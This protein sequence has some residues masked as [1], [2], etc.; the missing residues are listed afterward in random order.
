MSHIVRPPSSMSLQF[1]DNMG[2]V[3]S[4]RTPSPLV[5]DS[6][7]KLHSL[8]SILAVVRMRLLVLKAISQIVYAIDHSGLLSDSFYRSIAETLLKDAHEIHAAHSTTQQAHLYLSQLAAEAQHEIMI[9]HHLFQL[10]YALDHFH[11]KS[12]STHLYSV[13]QNC[14]ALVSLHTQSIP[15]VRTSNW[16]RDLHVPSSTKWF[17]NFYDHMEAKMTLYFDQLLRRNH[18][19]ITNQ[20][21]S[22]L[23]YRR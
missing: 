23:F 12:A 14:I 15:V 10:Q 11:F 20:S 16:C 9:L 3:S 7:M 5:D 1:F 13:K 2:S 18:D 4:G 6:G 8:H 17:L 22:F 21:N 19:V